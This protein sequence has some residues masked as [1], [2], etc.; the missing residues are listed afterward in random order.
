[1]TMILNISFEGG[2]TKRITEGKVTKLYDD[3]TIQLMNGFHYYEFT[4]NNGEKVFINLKKITDIKLEH[5][6]HL[7]Y[8]EFVVQT[9][10]GGEY[11]AQGKEAKKA[12]DVLKDAISSGLKSMTFRDSE[13]SYSTT[14]MIDKITKF[15][16]VKG[17]EE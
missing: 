4:G 15:M 6:D 5:N 12:H 10:D 3:I 2:K 11:C 14:I 9:V 17:E 16:Y 7:K 1:M 8:G 13:D